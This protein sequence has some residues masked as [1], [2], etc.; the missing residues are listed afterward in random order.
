M[1]Q[2][3][4]PPVQIPLVDPGNPN[5]TS[6]SYPL[7]VV[8]GMLNTNAGMAVLMTIRHAATTLPLCMPP[9]VAIQIGNELVRVASN[10]PRASGLVLPPGVA[11]NLPSS[12]DRNGQPPAPT[13]K[14]NPQV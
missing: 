6:Q 8:F 9:D 14:D 13:G 11:L 2:P 1:T 5:A 7:N 4:M 10:L 3:N 12:A